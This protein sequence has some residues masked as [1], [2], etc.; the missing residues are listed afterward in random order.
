MEMNKLRFTHIHTDT[1][2]QREFWAL[3]SCVLYSIVINNQPVIVHL[4]QLV[5]ETNFR[6]GFD[7]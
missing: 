1:H 2:I 7:E 3:W 5:V 6:I 4:H